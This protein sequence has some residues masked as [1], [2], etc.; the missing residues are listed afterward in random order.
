MDTGSESEG[1]IEEDEDEEEDGDEFDEEEEIEEVGLGDDEEEEIE[2]EEEEIEEEGELEKAFRIEKSRR[3]KAGEMLFSDDESSPPTLDSKLESFGYDF[4]QIQLSM[5]ERVKMRR[6]K[7]PLEKKDKAR[8]KKK[9]QKKLP[10]KPKIVRKKTVGKK[11]ND[12]DIF[13]DDDDLLPPPPT[14]TTTTTENLSPKLPPPKPSPKKPRKVRGGRWAQ[15]DPVLRELKMQQSH[16][17]KDFSDL[18]EEDRQFLCLAERDVFIR[19]EDFGYIIPEPPLFFEEMA[20]LKA[21]QVTRQAEKAVVVGSATGLV[22]EMVGVGGTKATKKQRQKMKELHKVQEKLKENRVIHKTGCARTEGRYQIR[23]EDK[24]YTQRGLLSS[25]QPE[26]HTF[27]ETPQPLDEAAARRNVNSSKRQNRT[28]L[29]R[30][31]EEC[32]FVDGDADALHASDLKYRGK[33]VKFGKS[34]IHDWGLFALERIEVDEMVI[35]Y[36]GELVRDKVADIREKTYE[37]Q[38]MGSSYMF[39]IDDSHIIDATRK[40][41]LARF[42]NHSCDPNCNAKVITI[43]WNQKDWDLQWS[44]D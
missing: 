23:H 27:F 22:T 21:E 41:N 14:T 1:E 44:C 38:G 2:E 25:L 43:T 16:E 3:E 40:G 42:I 26:Q 19:G 11:I 24:W 30:Q 37:K 36:V 18:D 13:S 32:R 34:R 5:H 10:P 29:R 4:N 17:V 33:R 35:E 8:K 39:R 31:V 20:I 28:A 12:E 6:S 9:N 15:P 7:K